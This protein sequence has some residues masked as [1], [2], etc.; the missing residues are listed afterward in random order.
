MGIPTI[1]LLGSK[2]CSV[3]Q[4]TYLVLLMGPR[5]VAI[6]VVGLYTLILL[7]RHSIW[8]NPND[9]DHIHSSVHPSALFRVVFSCN[10]WQLTQ[11]LSTG[12]H[13]ETKKL[14][15][16]HPKW[17]KYLWR[18]GAERLWESEVVDD[19]N[20]MVY[21]G[22]QWGSCMYDLTPVVT[23]C[24][25]HA[26]AQAWQSHSSSWEGGHQISLLAEELLTF[27]SCWETEVSFS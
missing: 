25:W 16:A 18:W 1:F 7:N 17:L 11:R 3:R 27:D 8:K 14:W 12:Q 21:F 22:A 15:S 20:Q 19:S 6:Y 9:Y 24:A 26:Q 23:V 5:T 4:N 10:G 2:T 13:V